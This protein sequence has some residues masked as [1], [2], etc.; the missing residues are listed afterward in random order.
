MADGPDD[1]TLSLEQIEKA[2]WGNAPEGATKL[3]RDAHELRRKPVRELT[4]GDLRLLLSQ[5]VGVEVLTPEALRVLRHDPLA[6]GDYYPGDLLVAVLKLPT[7]Y[8]DAHP[9]ELAAVQRIAGSVE[10]AD[11]ELR[12]DINRFLA[13]TSD[14]T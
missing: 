8:W 11:A 4:A 14:R 6:E 2:S 7:S 12:G 9:G 1:G 3:I 5:R 13:R 10:D